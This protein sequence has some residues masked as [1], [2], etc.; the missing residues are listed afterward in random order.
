MVNLDTI[1]CLFW[2][3]IFVVAHT[4][5]ISIQDY[6]CFPCGGTED[7][8]EGAE[9]SEVQGEAVCKDTGLDLGSQF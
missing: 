7:C 5:F 2:K 4:L 1:G 8:E 9:N 6:S 3:E